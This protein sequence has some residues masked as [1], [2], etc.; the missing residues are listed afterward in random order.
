MEEY[1]LESLVPYIDGMALDKIHDDTL[2]PYIAARCAAGL[3]HKTINLHSESRGGFC[4][5]LRR[6]GGTTSQAGHEDVN[7]NAS[8]RSTN[9]G[10]LPSPRARHAA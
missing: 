3:S 5:L 8:S 1:L 2:A 7:C 9:K 6:C 4:G 10:L